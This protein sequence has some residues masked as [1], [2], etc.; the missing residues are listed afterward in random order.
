MENQWQLQ[1]RIRQ[2]A[3]QDAE[4]RN[5]ALHDL[6][7]WMDT[8]KITKSVISSPAEG[9]CEEIHTRGNEYFAAKQFKEALEC[10]TRCLESKELLKTPVLIYSNRAAVFLK[11]KQFA[12]AE[13]DASSALLICSTHSK[14]LHRRAVARLSLGKLRAATLD[15]YAAE[16]NCETTGVLKDIEILKSKCEQA[17]VEAAKRAPR[18]NVRISVE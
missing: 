9:T 7:T 4:E 6:S 17:L 1:Q 5:S 14:S 15:V 16:D 3:V 8:L 11:L 13:A 10:Y 12:K 2:D 18:R